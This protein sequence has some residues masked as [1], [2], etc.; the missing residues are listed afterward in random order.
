MRRRLLSLLRWTTEKGNVEAGGVPEIYYSRK[1]VTK[2]NTNTNML[3]PR[4]NIDGPE[5]TKRVMKSP[6]RPK[7]IQDEVRKATFW[8]MKK[9]REKGVLIPAESKNRQG[10][11]SK[12]GNTGGILGVGRRP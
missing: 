4:K 6:P 12:T 7:T 10:K 5:S 3:V 2:H 11:R 8:K 1:V 9:E